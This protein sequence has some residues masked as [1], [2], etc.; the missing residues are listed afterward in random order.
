MNRD[1]KL[2]RYEDYYQDFLKNTITTWDSYSLA[3]CLK[4]MFEKYSK[5]SIKDVVKNVDKQ[6]EIYIRN[7]LVKATILL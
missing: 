7:F 5:D 3:L 6:K 1:K 2:M 4:E